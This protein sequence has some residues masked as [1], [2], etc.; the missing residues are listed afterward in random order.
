MMMMIFPYSSGVL[1]SLLASPSSRFF[2][3]FTASPEFSLYPSRSFLSFCTIFIIIILVII[4]ISLWQL[5]PNKDDE[6]GS[7]ERC[8]LSF[9]VVLYSLPEIS[10]PT[11]SLLCSLFPLSVSSSVSLSLASSLYFASYLCLTLRAFA[12]P[13]QAKRY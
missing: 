9:R 11:I 1:A 2:V 12:T 13:F 5:N 4:F 6:N 10:S 8:F 7:K 3:P